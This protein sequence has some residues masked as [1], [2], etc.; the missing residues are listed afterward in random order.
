MTTREEVLKY[1]LS[2]P[3]TYQDA[4]FHDEN[5]QLVRYHKNKKVFSWTYIRDGKLWVNVKVI[6]SG[7]LCG[8]RPI[9]PCL[10][11]II[12]IR[13]IGIQLF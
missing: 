7:E 11:D 5:W 10:R 2:F 6:L 12:R 13:S 1:C 3:D 8:G 9:R 4:P